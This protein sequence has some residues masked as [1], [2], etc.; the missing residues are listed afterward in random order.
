MTDIHAAAERLNKR[1][2]LPLLGCTWKRGVMLA[3]C[4]CRLRKPASC[5]GRLTTCRRLW[6][7]LRSDCRRKLG[8]DRCLLV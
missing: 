4:S 1:H 3:R 8:I 6:R 2:A 5:C 7:T